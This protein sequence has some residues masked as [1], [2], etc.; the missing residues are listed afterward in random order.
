[1]LESIIDTVKSEVIAS[2]TK[3]TGLG[4][5]EAEQTVPLAK[6]SVTEGL[7]GA[8]TG[9]NL[10]G[11]LDML[12]GADKES[13]GGGLLQNAVFQTIA[14]KFVHKLTAQLGLPEGVAQKVA[15]I[16]LPIVLGKLAGRTRQTGESDDIDKGSLLDVLGMDA[17]DVL[18]NLFG[19]KKDGKSGGLGNLFG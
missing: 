6:E 8:L 5:Q 4:P 1:M 12:R 3:Q 18:G 9:G 7:T 2:V 17:G 11:I 16:A 14:G 10:S 15:T 19:G 13:T